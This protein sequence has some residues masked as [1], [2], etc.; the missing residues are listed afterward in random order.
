MNAS[1]ENDRPAVLILGTQV[2]FTRGGAELLIDRLKQELAARGCD[3]DV[4]ALPFNALPKTGLVHQVAMWR[5][6]DVSSFAGRRVDLVIGTKFPSY[7]V[8]HPRKVLWMIHQHRQ[9]YE[10]YGT[11]FGDFEATPED[12]ALRRLLVQADVQSLAECS[13]IFTISDNVSVR[14]KRFLDVDSVPLPPPPPLGDSYRSGDKGRYILSVGRLCSIKRVDLILRA[15]PRIHHD[16][17]LKVVGAA[18]EPAIERYLKSEVDKH[19]LWERVELLGRVSDTELLD[20]YA[21]AFAVYYAPYDEDYGFV[22]IEALRSGKPVVTATDSGSTLEL[23]RDGDNG[24]VADP[25]EE[26]IATGFN[27][28]YRDPALYD[29]LVAGARSIRPSAS[30][31]DICTRLLSPLRESSTIGRIDG[32]PMEGF[33]R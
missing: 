13:R 7:A 24:V 5:A 23:V 2:P 33:G 14:L 11:R 8:K 30:W 17:T 9:I 26:G 27:A 20:L 22:T 4:V 28:M 31:E 12:E 25:T 16:L 29:R 10:L 18:D 32:A 3:V 19:H 21:G 15:M 6:L 1:S